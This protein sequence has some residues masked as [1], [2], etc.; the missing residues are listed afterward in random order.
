MHSIKKCNPYENKTEFF[1]HLQK[2][3]SNQTRTSS[4]TLKIH[5]ENGRNTRGDRENM[6]RQ[7]LRKRE[8]ERDRKIHNTYIDHYEHYSHS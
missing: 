3:Q 4:V 7:T 1:F 5:T 6:K 2:I 8:Q